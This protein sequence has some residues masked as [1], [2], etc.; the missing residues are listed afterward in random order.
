MI[1]ND[2]EASVL[3]RLAAPMMFGIL[4]MSIFNLMDTLF[5]GRLGTVELAALSFTFP[6]ILVVSSVSH[7]LGVGMTAAVSK[8]AGGN[9]RTKL[10]NIISWGLGLSVLIVILVVLLG[11]LTIEPLFR[12][13]GADKQTL[14]VIKEY[15]RIW[16]F[17]AV[18]VVIPMVGNA[19]IRGLG[20]T[21][22]PSMVM[23][24]AAIV[25]TILDP[26]L[27]F[28]IGPF[29]ELGVRGA[30]IATVAARGITF[31]VALWVL[32][33]REKIIS[34]ANP[35]KI[36]EVWKELL[37]V[38]IPNALSKMII[39]LGAA[40]I[41]RLIA[42]YGRESVAGFGVAGKLE[43]FALLPVMA[44][45]SVIP[46]FIGQNL[47]AG[48]KNRV[49]KGL[50]LSGLFSL[51]YGIIIYIILLLNG[52]FLGGLFNKNEKVIE[53]I[54]IYLSIVPIAY[55]FRSIMDLSITSLSVTGK[56]IQAALISLIQMFLLYIPMAYVGS[57]LFGIQGI[58]GALS[59]SL[60]LIGPVSYYIARRYIIKLP[61]I[62]PT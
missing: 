25:N 26:L 27:I 60:L 43:M 35:S 37:F 40:I 61:V 10:K 24:I 23:L 50:K 12:A 11:Q 17:G 21:K 5:V 3:L 52:G 20:D 7:G 1:T 62:H 28:G 31:T 16:Y 46:V 15:M 18:F 29:P 47:G 9:D 13:L 44:L 4:G 6:V 54:I 2:K 36:V 45:S 59:I 42:S 53:V 22:I 32:I 39:P 55:F 8:A 14:P 51:F 34:F 48:N 38:A 41:I 30:A 19:A 57:K 49:L 56:P 33:K 58:F